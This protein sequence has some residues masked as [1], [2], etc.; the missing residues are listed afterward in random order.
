MFIFKNAWLS[1]KRNKGRNVLIGIIVLIVACACTIALAIQNTATDLISSYKNAYEKEATIGFNRE[2]MMKDFDPSSRTESREN[3]RE[4]FENVASYTIDDVENFAESDYVESYYYTYSVGLNG[5]NIEKAEMES[6]GMGGKTPDAP[7]GMGHGM[8]NESTTD[9]TLTGYNSLEAM[10]EFVNGTYVMSE[11]AD[12]AWD[13]AFDGNYAFINEEL[14][15]YNDLKLNDTIKL[16]DE[17]GKT[18]DFEILGIFKENEEAE[19]GSISPF[20]NS[21]NKL[22]TNA[23][24]VE[25][26][27]SENSDLKATIYPT[28]VIDSY[29]NTD[30]LQQE[31]YEKG[32]D[33]NYIL[34]TNEETA[35]SAVSSIEN[36][37]TFATMFLVMTFVIGGA[38]LLVINMINIRERRYEI[39]V[40]RTIGVSKGKVTLQFVAE[41]TMVALAALIVGAGVGAVSS[42]GISNMLLANEINNSS[43]RATE[44]GR[45]FG[46]QDMGGNMPERGGDMPTQGDSKDAGTKGAIHG[47]GAPVVQAYDSIDAVVDAKVLLELLTVGLLLVLV[48]SLASMISI[49]R[50]SPLTILKERS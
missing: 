46:K 12:G 26:L 22:V 36:V 11:I 2:N 7:G 13:K 17:N 5:E 8:E 49:Q 16:A 24:A 3:M 23:E 37:S 21:A 32:L 43:E 41:L 50:F 29:D 4:K 15:T 35:N 40:L 19:P 38:V 20:S 42:Q 30:A 31:F 44:I 48:S 39:G 18:Y 10:S 45:N 9:F 14:A 47:M 34:Q 6:S 27:V 28:F 1:I 25:K 33:E